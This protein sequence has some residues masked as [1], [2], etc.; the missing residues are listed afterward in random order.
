MDGA[1]YY[2]ILAEN[3]IHSGQRDRQLKLVLAT[4]RAVWFQLNHCCTELEPRHDSSRSTGEGQ[5][6]PQGGSESEE[7]AGHTA[8][9]IR[10]SQRVATRRPQRQIVLKECHTINKTEITETL[11]KDSQKIERG[12]KKQFKGSLGGWTTKG[13][14]QI[15][16]KAT[17]L[18]I[19]IVGC[20]M[21]ASEIYLEQVKTL[22]KKN[23]I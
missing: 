2:L 21:T 6:A 18:I 23:Q 16:I 15:I 3:L 13:L 11:V 8:S 7:G 20:M 4:P 5:A 22:Y 9:V 17:A 12:P 19:F 14:P 10:S 1:I